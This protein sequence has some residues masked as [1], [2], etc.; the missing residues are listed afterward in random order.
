MRTF[1]EYIRD[2]RSSV[3]MTNKELASKLKLDSAN[4]CR[5]ENNK[6]NF[7]EKRLPKLAEIF[8]LNLKELREEYITD[9]IG[10]KIYESDCSSKLLKVAQK[11]AE[12]RRI[13]SGKF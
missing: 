10:K 5:I 9:Q 2:L 1:G 3:G 7:D 6:R 8:D 11:K 13:L 12:Y 4:L